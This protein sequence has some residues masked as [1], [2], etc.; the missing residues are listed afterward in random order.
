MAEFGE[1]FRPIDYYTINKPYQLS[2]ALF[3]DP[4]NEGAIFDF[5]TGKKITV[6]TIE[7][8]RR[9]GKQGRTG[10]AWS[11]PIDEVHFEMFIGGSDRE[12]SLIHELIHLIY[13]AGGW[14][15]Y[16][17]DAHRMESMI[18]EAAVQFVNDHPAFCRDVHNVLM[19][20]NNLR[21]LQ[22]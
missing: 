21:Y 9:R 17:T 4:L 20:K 15:P 3:H 7:E 11:E 22:I 13:R 2:S 12:V 10:E 18:E 8:L 19:R 5:I 6:V 16:S 14:A 1:G